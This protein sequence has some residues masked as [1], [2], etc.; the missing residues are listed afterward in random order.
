VNP[1]ERP[2]QGERGLT[3]HPV[4]T[5]EPEPIECARIVHTPVACTDLSRAADAVAHLDQAGTATDGFL[6]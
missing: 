2:V 6:E 5:V 4:R 1:R 3:A